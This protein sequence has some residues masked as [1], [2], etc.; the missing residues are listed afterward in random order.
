MRKL[1][2]GHNKNHFIPLIFSWD[3]SN[4][5]VLRLIEKSHNLI[6]QEHFGP[7]LWNQNFPNMK[8]V[9]AYSNYSNTNSHYRPNW[10]K[11]KELRKKNNF[12]TLVLA[13]FRHLGGK[14][15]FSQNLALS[16]TTLH[17]PQTPCWVIEKT[18]EPI[19][20]KTEGL[21][22]LIHIYDP[23]GHGQGSYKRISQLRGIAADNKNKI[24]YNSA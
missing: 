9:Q 22:D 5:I 19:P 7:Y 14:T 4:F 6:S 2:D 8:F 11:I 1:L 18:K 24:Q 15:L 10:E 17:G 13:Y 3:P 12:R 23:Y 20:R 16:F 21:T